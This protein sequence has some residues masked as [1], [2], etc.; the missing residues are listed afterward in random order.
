MSNPLLEQN[1]LPVFDQITPEVIQPAIETILHDNRLM[2]KQLVENN[3][4]DWQNLM[5]PL[6]LMEDRLSKAWSPIRHLN[7]VKSSD[8]LREAY[9]HCLPLLSEYS[10]ELSQNKDVHD[11]VTQIS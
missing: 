6:A 4:P 7:S 3:Q 9:N 8:E 10:T 5:N 2:V 11:R 1:T